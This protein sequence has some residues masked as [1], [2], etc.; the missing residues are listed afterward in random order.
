MMLKN[1]IVC[2]IMLIFINFGIHA[3]YAVELDEVYK[4]IGPYRIV[5]SDGLRVYYPESCVKSIPRV[6]LSLQRVK[7]RLEN[8]FPEQAKSEISVLLTD[9][10]DRDNS[11][12]DATFDLI[13]LGL[14]EEMD[15]LSSE[16]YSLEERFALRLAHIYILKNLG[17]A[18]VGIRRRF[19]LLSIPQWF[20]EG[21]ALHYAFPM[22]AL[23]TSRLLELSRLD[24]LHG[25]DD[26]DSMIDKDSLTREELKSQVHDMMDFWHSKTEENSG[27]RILKAMSAR[28]IIFEDYFQKVF[29]MSVKEAFRAYKE[30]MKELCTI[31]DR[32]T[33]EIPPTL[34][35]YGGGKFYQSLRFLASDTCLWVSSR[36]HSEEVY[37]LWKKNGA[38]KPRPVLKN[39]HPALWVDTAS[40]SIYVGRFGVTSQRQRRLSLW[41]IPREGTPY[42]L[43]AE[44]GS[45]KPLGIF[46][47]RLFFMNIA[48]GRVRLMSTDP[49][50]SGKAREE[51]VFPDELRPLDLAMD[52]NGL[53]LYF[54]LRD[55]NKSRICRVPLNEDASFKS[56]VVYSQ[57]GM[58]RKIV[59]DKNGI[60]FCG[61]ADFNTL[62]LF[63]LE[64]I[65][66]GELF[67]CSRIPGGIWDFCVK[68]DD[69]F[70]ITIRQ[71]GFWPIRISKKALKKIESFKREE[72]IALN[73]VSF[74]PI[75]GKKYTKEFR[76]SYWLPKI[77]RDD[78][79][80]IFGVYSYKADRLDR[81][82]LV[83]S[84]TFG[85]KS[86]NWG[87]MADLMERWGLFKTGVTLQDQVIRKSYLSNSYYERVRSSDLHFSYPFNLSTLLTVGGNLTHR[88]IAKFPDRGGAYPTG[89]RD[90][91]VYGSVFHRAIRTEPYWEIF[92]RKGRVLQA[93]YRKGLDVFSGQ[94]KYDS[95]SLRMEEY[96][97]LQDDWVFTIRGWAAEDDKEGDIRRPDDL[98]L[99]G[100]DFLRGYPGSVRYGDSLRAYSFHFTHPIPLNVSVFRQWIHKQIIVGELFWENGDARY[101]GRKFSYLQDRG[102]EIRAKGLLLRRLPI[103]IRWG[104]AWPNDGGPRHGYWG[105]DVSALT[106]LVQ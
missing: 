82:R 6:L 60:W 91:S 30:H 81:N 72:E 96:F 94:L 86:R 27:I 80:A 103:T 44:P 65:G 7:K 70:A 8:F 19:G 32:S 68:G 55:E 21:L 31:K 56:W 9:Q 88:G 83:V 17:S 47:G 76:S 87:Y 13:T 24:R 57:I 29:H 10:D 3:V 46:N 28:P 104:T 40:E 66:D 79:G 37:D 52:E 75:E 22:D 5:A 90:H 1:I 33:L 23:H 42:C 45:F 102:I 95:F 100:S 41:R 59:I 16:G 49:V 99:G 93:S 92:P 35:N 85:Y 50:L 69:I 58:I 63:K 74:P 98:S 12:T 48:S 84:P 67:Q 43:I 105:V 18:R 51:F 101:S 15:S 64:Q 4:F 25:L 53:F 61:E 89:G 34:E 73:M 71:D 97:P 106:G 38:H 20:F 2:L 78:Q 14:F 62:Q 26:F 39:V 11:S 36:R 77:N 54:L